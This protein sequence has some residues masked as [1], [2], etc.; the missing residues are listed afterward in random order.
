M[1]VLVACEYSGTV[2]DAFI[3]RGHDAISCDLLPTDVPGPHYQGDVFDIIGDGFDLMIAHPP[4]THLA[5]SGARHFAAKRADGRQQAA[6]DFVRRLLDAPIPKIALE[7]PVSIISSRIRKPGQIIQPWQ[8]GHGETK[9][10]CLWLKGLPKLVPTN[11][12][13]GREHRVHLMPPG[14]NRWKE[15]SKTFQGI[16]DAMAEQWGSLDTPPRQVKAG[17]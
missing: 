7:N 2:R 8:F 17:G 4:C 14:P 3:K 13:S 1:K 15:R 6:L 16:A 11:I 9:A 5:V 12:V 10:T